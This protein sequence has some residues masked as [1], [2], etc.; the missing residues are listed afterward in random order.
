MR[1]E[2]RVASTE[3]TVLEPD[4]APLANCEVT[5]EQLG[6]G[7]GF[8]NIG[9][10][11]V[12]GEA[13]TFADDWLELFDA[14]TLPFYWGEFEPRRGQPRTAELRA[15]A[16]WFVEHGVAVKGHPLMWHTLAPDWLLGAP[17]GEVEA[18]VRQRIRRDAGGFR[19]LLSAWDVINETVIMPVF[20]NG[21]NAITPLA[22]VR[23][24]LGAIR[25][26]FDEARAADPD[27]SL[28]INDFDLSASYEHVIEEALA[29][30]VPIDAIGIQT[31]MHQGFRGTGQLL[32]IADRFARF[33]LPLHFTE[34]SLVSGDLMPAHIVDLNDHVV[35]AWPSTPEGEA[36]QADELEA[37][38]RAL[39]GH[40]A[41]DSITLWGFTDAGAWLNAPVG[42]VRADGSRKPSFDRLRSLIKGEWWMPPTTLRTDVAGRVR[43]EG[44]R[45]RYR[46]AVAGS[47]AEFEL[48]GAVTARL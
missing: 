36:R 2:H 41:V 33:G 25:M 10:E 9:F 8:G 19:G 4:G 42:L 46:V 37:H 6:H 22:A 48:G 12:G 17:V 39:F 27:A 44:V 24:R 32:E 13:P 30:D 15:A 5:V 16:E 7:F 43:V 40:P 26:A 14:V 21:D 1:P 23:G 29:A 35:D 34:T 38:Y 3:L 20:A 18:A 47:S 11:W 31:H 45:G 28:L